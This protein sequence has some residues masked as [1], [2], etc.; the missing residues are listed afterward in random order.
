MR[1]TF[2]YSLRVFES[3]RM[4]WERKKK[5][6]KGG[7]NDARKKKKKKKENMTGTRDLSHLGLLLLLL[8]VPTQ[9]VTPTHHQSIT[10]VCRFSRTAASGF[11]NCSIVQDLAERHSRALFLL[12]DLLQLPTGLRRDSHQHLASCTHQRVGSDR[13]GSI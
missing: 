6:K 11:F 1:I 3:L 7:K 12:P 10:S 13:V 4:R 9:T 2:F 8:L 5:R